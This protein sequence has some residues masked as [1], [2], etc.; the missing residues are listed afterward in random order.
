MQQNRL[1]TNNYQLDSYSTLI[2]AKYLKTETDFINIICVCKKF[3]ETTE[4][5]RFNPIPTKSLKLFPKIQTQYLYSEKDKKLK[6]IN[7]YEIWYTVT[8]DQY[9]EFKKKE[10]K[11]HNITYTTD[12]IIKYGE[13]IP[14]LVNSL[15]P[16]CFFDFYELP[17]ITLPSSITSLGNDCFKQCS[18]LESI[19]LPSTI[20]SFGN[21][22]FLNCIFLQS[23]NLPPSLQS[24]GCACFYGCMSLKLIDIPSTITSLGDECFK[25]CRSLKLVNLQ[26]TITSLGNCCFYGCSN[27]ETIN[28]VKKLKIGKYCFK[29]CNKLINKPTNS[30]CVIS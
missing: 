23:I 19:D 21:S 3:K 13:K 7:N 24:L 11:C 2:C 26:T 28:G 17:S 4:K 1:S 6:G 20:K 16:G 29:E 25:Y 14:I 10:V 8:Y 22:C 27:L 18:S 12:D 9:L 30:S 15:A 5:L